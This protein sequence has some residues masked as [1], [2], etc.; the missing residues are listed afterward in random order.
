MTA[1]MTKAE[2]VSLGRDKASFWAESNTQCQIVGFLRRVLPDSYRV[3]SIPNGRF[4]ADPTTI[5][6]LKREGLTPGAPDLLLL[7]N[8]GWF[9]GIEVKADKGRLSPEQTEWADWQT[10]GAS[11]F[12][13][14][15]SL[16]EAIAV[17]KQWNVPLTKRAA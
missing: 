3:I 8:D 14:V 10:R 4:K 12:A 11:E 1:R 9:A 2:A 15:R 6:R 13:T 17:L 7:R 5:A 16:D